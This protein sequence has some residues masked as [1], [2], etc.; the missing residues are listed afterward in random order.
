MRM[1]SRSRTHCH[2]AMR[3]TTER[4]CPGPCFWMS[5]MHGG[6]RSLGEAEFQEPRLGLGPLAVDH[7]AEA[8]LKGERVTRARGTQ[9]LNLT[10][11]APDIQEAVMAI[12][13]V[14]GVQPTGERGPREVVGAVDWAEQRTRWIELDARADGR[15]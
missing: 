2:E 4:S 11:L 10:L 12:E 7:H 8:L 5:S 3:C 1:S 9:F 15:G 6:S 13:A 14:D